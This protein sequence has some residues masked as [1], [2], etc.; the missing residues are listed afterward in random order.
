M[1]L[2]DALRIANTPQHGPPF[3]VLLACGFTP[4]HLETAVKAHFRL[5]LPDRTICMRTG[6]YADV[7]GTLENNRHEY[8]AILVVLEWADL[9]PRLG[10][11]ST[12]P[13]A[14]EILEDARVALQ[15]IAK[16][17]DACAAGAPVA[18][19]LPT[20]PVVPHL[21]N[22]QTQVTHLQAALWEIAYRFASTTRAKVV[23]VAVQQSST[24][25]DLRS[26]LQ[27]GFPYSFSHAEEVAARLVRAVAPAARKKGLITDL[28]ETLW[29]GVL[30][31]DGLE[32][33]AWDLDRHA[34]FHGLYQ[35]LLNTLG[36]SGVLLGVAS[37]NDPKLVRAALRRHDLVVNPEF[38]FPVEAHWL[39]KQDSIRRILELWN[40]GE[41]SVV[42]VDDDAWEIEQMKAAF[43]NI[44][45]AHFQRDDP[46][47]LSSLRA[48]FAKENVLETDR[49]RVPSLRASHS[50]RGTS[51]GSTLEHL[52]EGA[53]AK[54]H[55]TWAK[56]PPNER[57]FELVNK[58][59]QF[60]LNGR[61]YTRAEWSR[62]L[63]DSATYLLV[64]EYEDRFANLGEIAVVAGRADGDLFRVETWVM[65]CRALSRRIE[66]QCLNL[67]FRRWAGVALHH[68]ETTRNE[69]F[70]D[71]LAQIHV[72][73]VPIRREQFESVCP[74]LFHE[75]QVR[76]H[77]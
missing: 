17:V 58:T 41:D 27:N 30:G 23:H 19:S 26:E 75:V 16:A 2:I 53:H 62:F 9:D 31:E 21:Q 32:G 36:E 5:T 48:K 43:P 57:A 38:L 24:A 66:H 71:F 54:I 1:K 72:N 44:E 55:A 34:H 8:D 73:S 20:L 65:S 49:L 3:H 6:L 39:P 77:E 12:A 51:G 60:N 4:L 35:R 76:I 10:W 70:R 28:D 37:K 61:R 63:S 40:V 64:V 45:F 29:K 68:R 13:A 67:L 56:K 25:H 69:P 14:K 52:L 47:F 33:I 59:N 7:A 42:V 74:Q 18:V 50:L 11:R 22:E 15:R 46:Q